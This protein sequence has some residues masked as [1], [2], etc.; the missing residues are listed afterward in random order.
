M[1]RE[2]ARAGPGSLPERG[3]WI[4]KYEHG[5]WNV[6]AV[7]TQKSVA[8]QLMTLGPRKAPS[9]ELRMPWADGELRVLAT[10]PMSPI[11][12]RRWALRD[13]QLAATAEY[14]ANQVDD[15]A[16]L[17]GDLNVTPWST[18]FGGLLETA[19]LRDSA[20]GDGWQPSWPS[21][22]GIF[23]IPIDHCLLRGDIVAAER[24]IGPNLGSD[25][26][27]LLVTIAAAA[28]S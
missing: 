23:G 26:L 7:P 13:E 28:G 27:P 8:R 1:L 19:R 5:P 22:L 9:A 18:A 15:P 11:G 20:R 3:Y 24:S 16:V 25:H 21:R 12:G 10:H 2:F 6:E 17:I 4:A 14:L